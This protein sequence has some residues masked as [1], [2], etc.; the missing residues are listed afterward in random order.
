MTLNCWLL[1]CPAHI[2][3]T[4]RPTDLVS[5]SLVVTFASPV[6]TLPALPSSTL[7]TSRPRYEARQGGLRA[8]TAAQEAHGVSRDGQD[9]HLP[10]AMLWCW[11]PDWMFVIC[12]P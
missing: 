12:T 4:S 3:S 6:G 1:D 10:P 11:S 8:G 7:P 2:L 9:C 5:R